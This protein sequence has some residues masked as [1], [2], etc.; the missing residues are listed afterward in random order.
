[1]TL[2]G[3]AFI[4]VRFF[5]RQISRLLR[6]R[7]GRNLSLLVEGL[8]GGGRGPPVSRRCADW[9]GDYR[10]RLFAD[11]PIAGRRGCAQS[12]TGIRG[13]ALGVRSVSGSGPTDLP[14]QRPADAVY[15]LSA[16]LSSGRGL[17]SL[18]RGG[19]PSPAA[20]NIVVKKGRVFP[21]LSQR[22]LLA[23]ICQ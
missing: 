1:M 23:A 10:L 6:R 19:C 22:A 21:P 17:R 16:G 4:A 15:R 13:T 5:L 3:I 8:T 14:D 7:H 2:F 18:G 20:G 11:V 12:A 9:R